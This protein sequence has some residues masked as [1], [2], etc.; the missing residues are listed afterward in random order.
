M[1]YSR[2]HVLVRING[3]FGSTTNVRDR[4]SIGLRMASLSA[5]APETDFT[6]FLTAFHSD[7]AAFHAHADVGA[8]S[9]CYYTFL[10]AAKIGVDGKYSPKTQLTSRYD[11]PSAIAGS[12]TCDSP[13]S[14]AQVC[15]LR[16]ALPRGYA[17]NGRL[18]YPMTHINGLIDPAT[19]RIAPG[20]VAPLLARWKI[21]IEAANTKFN[22]VLGVPLKVSVM[23]QVGSGTTAVVNSLRM[24][25]R[26]DAQERR[27]NDQPAVWSTTTIA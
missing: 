3:I 25:G 14:Q 11:A 1:P 9:T 18:Y 13:F 7:V 4:W 15:S 2:E 10:T 8:G 22:A 6:A 21:L 27:E 23:S 24:D 17:S 5:V 26:L 20:V 19:G 12:G 16:T